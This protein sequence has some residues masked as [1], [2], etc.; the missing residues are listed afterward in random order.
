MKKKK[1]IEF[2]L[3]VFSSLDLYLK[4]SPPYVWATANQRVVV[5]PAAEPHGML[6]LEAFPASKNQT[7]WQEN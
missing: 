4:Y 3:S 2:T 1:R 5:L 6:A 7:I